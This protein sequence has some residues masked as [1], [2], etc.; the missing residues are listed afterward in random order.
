[1]G[2]RYDIEHLYQDDLFYIYN[3]EDTDGAGHSDA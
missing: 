2:A 1:M 3:T